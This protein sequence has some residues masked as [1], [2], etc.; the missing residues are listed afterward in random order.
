MGDRSEFKPLE[1]QGRTLTL[2]PNALVKDVE[3]VSPERLSMNDPRM[4]SAMKV[5]GCTVEDLASP[6]PPPMKKAL[7]PGSPRKAPHSAETTKR[8]FELWE[9]KRQELLMEVEAMASNFELSDALRILAPDMGAFAKEK[10][11]QA[12][13]RPEDGD[14]KIEALRAQAKAEAQK[15]VDDHR[16]KIQALAESAERE[17]NAKKRV[18]EL[19][20]EKYAQLL[21]RIKA[22]EAKEAK[23]DE[24]LVAHEKERKEMSRSLMKKMTGAFD[25]VQQH[26]QLTTENWAKARDERNAHMGDVLDRK[27]ESQQFAQEEMIRLYKEKEEKIME[28][29]DRKR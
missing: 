21:E 2:A 5:L 13:L 4:L 25:K 23:K 19:K 1:S 11:E 3:E 9:R 8:R 12:V 15:I 26:Q 14:N 29:M 22:R 28:R 6:T 18:A 10:A 20:G 7:G 16:A 24:R 27:S 17:E